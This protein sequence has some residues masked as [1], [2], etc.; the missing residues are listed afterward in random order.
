MSIK[1]ASQRNCGYERRYL[2]PVE[3]YPFLPI[4]GQ[5]HKRNQ[6][7]DI[8][9]GETDVGCCPL[10][11]DSPAPTFTDLSFL[12]ETFYQ[13][14]GVDPCDRNP[15]DNKCRREPVNPTCVKPTCPC[16]PIKPCNSCSSEDT[17]EAWLGMCPD[18]QGE[19]VSSVNST[20]PCR[21]CGN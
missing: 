18:G 3:S 8:D 10:P 13:I 17:A 12:A 20:K 6:C 19:Q 7:C 1:A 5:G 14:P 16:K 4:P 2:D 21:S 9:L 11:S 15:C